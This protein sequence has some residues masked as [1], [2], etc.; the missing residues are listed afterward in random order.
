MGKHPGAPTKQ[1]SHFWGGSTT[2]QPAAGAVNPTYYFSRYQ[3]SSGR[4]T[5]SMCHDPHLDNL[6]APKLLRVVV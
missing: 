1:T 3:I 5:C 2:V 6:T 4:V